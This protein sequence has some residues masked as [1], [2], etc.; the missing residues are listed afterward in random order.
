[1]LGTGFEPKSQPLSPAAPIK[2]GALAQQK[3]AWFCR[4]P[5]FGSQP[6]MAAHSFREN[7]RPLLA[8][9]MNLDRCTQ[10]THTQKIRNKQHY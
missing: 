5:E 3:S 6:H 1:M 2:A 7:R 9:G 4:G 8:P 10:N